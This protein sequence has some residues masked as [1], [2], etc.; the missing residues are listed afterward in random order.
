MEHKKQ[1]SYRLQYHIMPPEGWLNDPNGLCYYRGRYH[2]FFQYSKKDVYGGLKS[3][4]H[5]VSEDLLSWEFLGE[6]VYPDTK[7]DK[8]GAYS[9]CA[10]VEDGCMEIFY[11]GNVKKEG[12]YDY[13][14]QGREANVL[15]L[16]ARD[17]VTFGR[18]ELLLTNANYPKEYTCHVRDPKVWKKGDRY[19][20]VLGGRKALD[21][22]A[23]LLYSSGDKKKWTYEREYTTKSP[24]GYMWECPDMFVLDGHP[25][26]AVCPQGLKPEEFR[27]QNRYQAGYFRLEG[28]MPVDFVEWDCGFDFYAPQTFEAQGRRILTGWA[29]VPEMEEEYDNSPTIAEGWQHSLTLFRELRWQNGKVYQY[30]VKEYEKLRREE[31]GAWERG[32]KEEQAAGKGQ[33]RKIQVPRTY[34]AEIIFPEG[35]R[36]KEILFGNSLR[37]RY[38]SGVAEL[39]FLDESGSGRRVRRALLKEFF[40]LRI[41]MDTSMVE[42]YLNGGEMV[43]TSRW[44][45]NTAKTNILN[46]KGG[47][48]EARIWKLAERLC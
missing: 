12:D 13:I 32:T 30:P 42:L 11:T 40:A 4:G 47:P 48:A 36:E 35:S 18:K 8:D 16:S 21:A 29:G 41:M 9:G 34:D 31:I 44:F 1:G 22:G 24:F 17:G 14:H 39:S 5:F 10:F 15:Y 28:E 46:I 25:V 2:V 20:M 3:W 43:F 27:F 33:E 6:A 45:G 19:Y 38:A 23:V 7:W 26:L 37:L